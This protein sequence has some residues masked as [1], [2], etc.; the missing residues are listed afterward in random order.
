MVFDICMLEVLIQLTG[1]VRAEWVVK[2]LERWIR[3]GFLDM[4]KNPLTWESKLSKNSKPKPLFSKIF[5]DVGIRSS[6]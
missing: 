4:N 2:V 3:T 6:K 1:P 5:C